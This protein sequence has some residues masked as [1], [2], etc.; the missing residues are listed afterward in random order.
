M[1]VNHCG[2]GISE[3]THLRDF[4]LIQD[5]PRIREENAAAEGD[6]ADQEGQQNDAGFQGKL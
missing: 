5:G 2:D 3:L 1:L 6:H 4:V